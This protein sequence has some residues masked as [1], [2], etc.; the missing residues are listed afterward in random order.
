[1]FGDG[2]GEIHQSGGGDFGGG[3]VLGDAFGWL[4]MGTKKREDGD[5]QVVGVV[6]LYDMHLVLYRV[7]ATTIE[8]KNV[9]KSCI[10]FVYR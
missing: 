1:M 10:V 5:L 8:T 7:Q 6:M 2:G 9:Q 4:R 3:K